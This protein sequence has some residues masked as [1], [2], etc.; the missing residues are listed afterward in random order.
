M[1]FKKSLII[2]NG[3][4]H[5]FAAGIWLAAM[6]TIWLLH[7]THIA[8]T[9][10]VSVINLLERQFFWASIVS[11]A[12]IMMTGAGRTFTYVDNWYGEDAEKMRRRM[13]IVKHIILFA[14]FA[15]G[16]FFIFNKAFH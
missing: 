13:L 11:M 5:D 14:V 2:L 4:V 8:H 10:I 16:Y 1:N 3:F 12:V 6:S 15:F 9:E 7:R